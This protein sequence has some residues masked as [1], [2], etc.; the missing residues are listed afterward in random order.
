MPLGV[1]ALFAGLVLPPWPFATALRDDEGLASDMDDAQNEDMMGTTSNF[2]LLDRDEFE[3]Y[4]GI[5]EYLPY[6]NY[7]TDFHRP[8]VKPDLQQLIIDIFTSIEPPHDDISSS[9]QVDI[10]ARRERFETILAATPSSPHRDPALGALLSEIYR[11]G[12][13]SDIETM[14][15]AMESDEQMGGIWSNID[16]VTHKLSKARPET[17]E[18]VGLMHELE[19]RRKEAVLTR[20]MQMLTL[21]FTKCTEV[22]LPHLRYL[23]FAKAMLQDV[24]PDSVLMWDTYGQNWDR[25]RDWFLSA[26]ERTLIN[27]DASS[28]YADLN[29]W[30]VLSLVQDDLLRCVAFMQANPVH[31][32]STFK[33]SFNADQHRK[34]KTKAVLGAVVNPVLILSRVGELANIL[35]TIGTGVLM[36]VDAAAAGVT[37]GAQ[38][39]NFAAGGRVED[40]PHSSWL[41]WIQSSLKE[42]DPFVMAMIARMAS[43]ATLSTSVWQDVMLGNIFDSYWKALKLLDNIVTESN[44]RAFHYSP[45]RVFSTETWPKTGPSSKFT[46]LFESKKSNGRLLVDVNLDTWYDEAGAKIEDKESADP[47]TVFVEAM[48]K[49]RAGNL[50]TVMMPITNVGKVLRYQIDPVANAAGVRTAEKSLEIFVPSNGHQVV[51]AGATNADLR[52]TG[53]HLYPGESF[54]VISRVRAHVTHPNGQTATSCWQLSLAV[55]WVCPPPDVELVGPLPPIEDN[56]MKA[57]QARI[58]QARIEQSKKDQQ[59]AKAHEVVNRDKRY[60]RVRNFAIGGAAVVGVCAVLCTGPLGMGAAAIV[61]GASTSSGVAVAAVGAGSAGAVLTAAPVTT[62]ALVTTGAFIL[63]AG[64][65]VGLTAFGTMAAI[66]TTSLV[67]TVALSTEAFGAN[68]LEAMATLRNERR[69]D[70]IAITLEKWEYFMMFGLTSDCDIRHVPPC[71][72]YDYHGGS[73]RQVCI[74]GGVFFKRSHFDPIG[75]C[76]PQLS[77]LPQDIPKDIGEFCAIH[78]ECHS[79][80]CHLLS[81]GREDQIDAWLKAQSKG[82]TFDQMLVAS[83]T[84]SLGVCQQPCELGTPRCAMISLNHKFGYIRPGEEEAEDGVEEQHPLKRGVNKL[85]KVTA[86]SNAVRSRRQDAMLSS[87]EGSQA[88]GTASQALWRASSGGAGVGGGRIKLGNSG[89]NDSGTASSN[90]AASAVVASEGVGAVVSH[91]K[92]G[93]PDKSALAGAASKGHKGP[94]RAPLPSDALS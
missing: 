5:D 12:N 28:I 40:S 57:H 60:R 58:E 74:R 2:T 90:P 89:V 37:N 63:Q 50:Q 30:A 33:H 62:A 15:T 69:T 45:S 55:G 27:A 47:Q 79:G 6:K 67:V 87:A 70:A 48:F 7:L 53:R 16:V 86:L 92:E 91:P 26:D 54:G 75:R 85:H 94:G 44:P 76:M 34:A 66:T 72:D 77:S 61:G 19:V 29:S 78:K 35:D 52:S 81:N 23:Q 31:F 49:D 43:G 84:Q 46:A 59:I 8:P 65:L 41:A 39:A 11:G 56:A 32:W 71:P 42:Q 18:E 22:P 3:L 51:P 9:V 36:S 93:Q 24:F 20:H 68:A 82:V 13:A 14:W 10:S 88:A 17:P 38:A 80:Y 4:D 73:Y 21:S 25:G 1:Y 83:I 64:M